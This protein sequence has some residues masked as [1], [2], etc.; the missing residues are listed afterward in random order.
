[1][2]LEIVSPL[3]WNEFSLS[4]RPIEYLFKVVGRDWRVV[5]VVFFVCFAY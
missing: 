3:N 1:M 5:V 4:V 2:N